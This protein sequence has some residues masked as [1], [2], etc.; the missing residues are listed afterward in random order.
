MIPVF[1]TRYGN[2]GNCYQAALASLLEL[3]IDGVPDFV[4]QY[5]PLWF[6]QCGQWLAARNLSIIEVR[7]P[8]L[9]PSMIYMPEQ[10]IYHLISGKSPRGLLH[11]VVALQGRMVHDPHPDGRGL[12]EPH[13]FD[14]LVAL[15]PAHH[16]DT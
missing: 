12:V 8:M 10:P 15:N 9:G 6:E 1:Q 11:S 2:S 16:K 3:P 5:G 14:F 13:S 4:H 7:I